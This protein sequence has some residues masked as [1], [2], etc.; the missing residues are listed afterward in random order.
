MI[1]VA[2]ANAARRALDAAKHWSRADNDNR[3]GDV[4]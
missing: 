2:M 4:Q 1:D 3:Q